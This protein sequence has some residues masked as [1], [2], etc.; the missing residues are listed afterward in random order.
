M[1]LRDSPV[2]EAR[3]LAGVQENRP[4]PKDCPIGVPDG[5]LIPR[6]TFQR[7]RYTDNRVLFA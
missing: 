2:V 3:T 1:D 7:Y 5:K 6:G 4:L